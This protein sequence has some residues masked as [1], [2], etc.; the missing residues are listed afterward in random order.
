MI[1]WDRIT[2]PAVR[3]GAVVRPPPREEL[4]VQ[5]TSSPTFVESSDVDSTHVDRQASDETATQ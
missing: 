1:G 3:P 2:G 5:T 4:R